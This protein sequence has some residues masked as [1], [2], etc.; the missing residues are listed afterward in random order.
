VND[1]KDKRIKPEK[2]CK[3]VS[4]LANADGGDLFVGVTEEK[5]TEGF[6]TFK[7]DG[8]RDEESAN[9]LIDVV[10]SVLHLQCHYDAEFLEC[11]DRR[12]D[13][14]VLHFTI[15]KSPGVIKTPGNKIYVRLS[16]QD[17]NYS[18]DPDKIK[19]LQL[20]KGITSCEDF[21]S[22]VDVTDVS[23][24]DTMYQFMISM[25]SLM[26]EP[27][28]FLRKNNL[29]KGSMCRIS[30]VLLFHDMPQAFVKRC[31][32][33][34]VSY[35]TSA[36]N[37]G[38]NDMINE[39]RS[40]EGC[41]CNLIY[42]TV[43]LIREMLNAFPFPDPCGVPAYPD[44]AIHEIVANAI[45]HRDY[46]IHDDVHVRIF[47]NRIEIESPGQLPGSVTEANILR[48]RFS[49]NS[50]IGRI[51]SKFPNR[52]N[53]DIGEGLNTAFN[54]M[55]KSGLNAPQIVSRESR[56]IVTLLSEKL[57]DPVESLLKLFDN[58]RRLSVHDIQYSRI[59]KSDNDRKAAINR[60][61]QDKVIEIVPGT[62]GKDTEYQLTKR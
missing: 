32:V 45:I 5:D 10:H 9:Q 55:R 44:E 43:D 31:G 22:D 19:Q 15:S 27:E 40:V 1:F 17:K 49:R 54:C 39:P 34:V 47:N 13:G 59:F 8:F 62:H 42:N 20:N 16:S 29:S 53:K 56:V 28:D 48:E 24:S 12:Q 25:G 4:A 61:K 38:R 58:R 14:L 21:L 18:D 11:S 50:N 33:R 52:P 36:S 26:S 30:G 41:L 2:L 6:V 23:E 3:T 60:L 57:P 46:S 51:L 7:W 35:A 37:P